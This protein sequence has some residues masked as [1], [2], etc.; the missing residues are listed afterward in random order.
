MMHYYKGLQPLCLCLSL[1]KL[2]LPHSLTR[3]LVLF[4]FVILPG[5]LPS[6]LAHLSDSSPG[7]GL[8]T[9]TL[10]PLMVRSR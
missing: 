6:L 1:S 8:K 4:F 9:E 5:L 3:P 7:S 2:H 10:S